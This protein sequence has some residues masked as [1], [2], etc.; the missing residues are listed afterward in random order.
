MINGTRNMENETK[1]MEDETGIIANG[2]DQA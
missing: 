2:W 1:G